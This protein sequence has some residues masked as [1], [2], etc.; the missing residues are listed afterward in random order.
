[1]SG[2]A[3]VEARYGVDWDA[4]T[5][6]L[7]HPLPMAGARRRD[8]DG[9]PYVV[10]LREPG[11]PVRTVVRSCAAR[12][13]LDVLVVGE[14][15]GVERE[16]R[17]VELW[18]DRLHLRRFREFAEPAAAAA[19]PSEAPGFDADIDPVRR[20]RVSVMSS[21]G[22]RFQTTAE[23]PHQHR[24]LARAPFGDW[25][26]YLEH[27]EDVTVSPA[28][29][30]N[31]GRQA[32]KE[33]APWPAWAELPGA[34]PRHLQALFT[35]GARLRDDDGIAEIQAPE[36]A[37][38]LRLPTG[39]VIAADPG[40][41]GRGLAG[42]DEPFTVTVP[43]GDYPVLIARMNWAGE[44]W[45]EIT[46]AKV[47]IRPDRPTASWELALRPGEDVRLLGDDEFY[48][49]GV[50]TGTGCFLD[51]AVL[52][53]FAVA[54]EEDTAVLGGGTGSGFPSWTDPATG[55]TLISY[56]SGMGDGSYPVWI[57]RDGEGEVTCLVADML[58][59]SR[60]EP[61]APT[62]EDDTPYR[63]PDTVSPPSGAPVCGP[64]A[65]A[66]EYLA[67]L[68]DS[69]EATAGSIRIRWP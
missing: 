5:G 58:I 22:G 61:I 52:D 48:G 7:V 23:I 54:R 47:E 24:T 60:A 56:P 34:R 32:D 65:D 30:D 17:Y 57:G 1:M 29:A 35:A 46:A 31:G 14:S 49:F 33:D 4:A 66:A 67:G 36:V 6:R 26:A 40:W 9:A 12:G 2:K 53:A 18:Q 28:D 45:G 15:G 41:V 63:V 19:E 51:A 68:R 69:T 39:E 42:R 37:G 27:P 3:V 50:D 11:G 62:A 64:F 13:V 21:G 55:G 25:S 44:Q 8:E 10:E 43:P 59:L 20:A 16:Y 38:T